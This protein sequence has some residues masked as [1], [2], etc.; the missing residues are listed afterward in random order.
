MVFIYHF[1]GLTL[2]IKLFISLDRE[3]DSLSFDIHVYC[4]NIKCL[5]TENTAEM[6]KM[7]YQPLSIRNSQRQIHIPAA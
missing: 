4:V 6:Q 3:M 1:S 5:G 7:P 2:I